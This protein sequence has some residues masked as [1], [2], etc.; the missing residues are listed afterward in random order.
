MEE[1]AGEDAPCEV[2]GV[3][4]LVNMMLFSA[5]FVIPSSGVVDDAPVR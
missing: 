4:S 3:E 1:S 2:A 5:S